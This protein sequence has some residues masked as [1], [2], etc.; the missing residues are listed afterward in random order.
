[1][2]LMVDNWIGGLKCNHWKHQY[3]NWTGFKTYQKGRVQIRL[4]AFHSLAMSSASAHTRYA[5][6]DMD[7]RPLCIDNCAT[8]SIS[9]YLP[10]FIAP[11]RPTP[12]CITGIG[13]AISDIKV[14]MV[15]WKIEDDQ[16]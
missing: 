12:H 16:G 15:R 8:C 11:P 10:D 4:F 7:S 14:G 9:N 2:G 6:F 1:M 3:N 5:K 13:G